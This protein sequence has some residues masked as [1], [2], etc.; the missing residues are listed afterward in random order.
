MEVYLACGNS[1]II[2][3]GFEKE[4]NQSRKRKIQEGYA[5]RLRPAGRLPMFGDF[6]FNHIFVLGNKILLLFHTYTYGHKYVLLNS[7]FFFFFF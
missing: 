3:S 4:K 7:I 5:D 6:G 2:N 1:S